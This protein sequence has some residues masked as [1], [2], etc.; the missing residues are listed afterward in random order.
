M[1][2]T[3]LLLQRSCPFGLAPPL[4]PPSHS[5][6][7]IEQPTDI[8]RHVCA[9]SHTSEPFLHAHGHV[10]LSTPPV[11]RYGAVPFD[12]SGNALSMAFRGFGRIIIECAFAEVTATA[13]QRAPRCITFNVFPP[14]KVTRS[15]RVLLR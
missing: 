11:Q 12:H 9:D 2:A 5:A 14:H 15:S 8:Q 13:N 6:Q 10:A 4:L 3:M 7:P 1:V